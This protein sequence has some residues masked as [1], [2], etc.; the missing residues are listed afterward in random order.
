MKI[1]SIELYNIGLYK[2]EKINFKTDKKNTTII[3]G[4]NG[5]GKTTLLNSIKLVLFGNA[6]FKLEYS[7]YV[8]FI[9][10]SVVSSRISKEI[11]NAK[12]KCELEIDENY[13][14]HDYLIERKY[15]I[16]NE[17]FDETVNVYCDER[18]LP[19]EEKEEFL[20]K[21]KLAIPPSLLDVIIFD[22]ENAID[23]LKSDQMS[24]LIKNIVHSVFGVDIYYNLIK[25]LNLYL[26]NMSSSESDDNN[27]FDLI[28]SENTYKALYN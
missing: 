14:K 13:E 5:A 15:K 11:L 23:I 6:A 7:D 24:K 26:K 8:K 27:K 16:K 1:K 28:E 18:L 3:W 22:G 4:N 9:K 19:F 2:N 25:D 12:I 17:N 10:E 20:N 21:I